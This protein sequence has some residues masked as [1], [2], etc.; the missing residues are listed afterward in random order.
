MVDDKKPEGE[1][2]RGEQR[3]GIIIY[4]LCVNVLKNNREEKRA[5]ILPFIWLLSRKEWRG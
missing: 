3:E 5:G 2:R 1:E 4:F